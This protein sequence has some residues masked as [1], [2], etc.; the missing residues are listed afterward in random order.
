[1]HMIL[2]LRST[3]YTITK[4]MSNFTRH[5]A[6]EGMLWHEK[7]P[8]D[9]AST[10]ENTA[11]ILHG[12]L[13]QGRNWRSFGKNLAQDAR[14]ETG[15]TW[16]VLN[17][18]L[19]CHGNSSRLPGFHPPHS[20]R[21][22]ATDVMRFIQH[23]LGGVQPKLVI[24]HS[25]GGKVALEYVRLLSETSNVQ[26]CPVWV[27]DSQPGTVA[28]D[29]VPDVQRVLDAVQKVALPV[30]HRGQFTADLKA[31]GFSDALV[32]WMASNLV[33]DPGAQSA[34]STGTKGRGPL[35]WAFDVYGAAELYASYRAVNSW[36]VVA[37]P[38]PK[39]TLHVLRAARSDRWTNGMVQT[40]QDCQSA[41][42]SGHA[43]GPCGKT[44][45]HVLANAGHWVHMDQPQ[46]LQS[47]ITDE[48]AT[49]MVRN[50]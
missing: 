45:S 36:D 4:C 32:Q 1:M 14:K 8:S 25:M 17:L 42:A 34:D 7:F 47:M 5:I 12:L 24:G 49:S 50:R 37:A 18:D 39:I 11:L 15:R 44:L 20:M 30:M 38:P 28:S 9:K 27:L 13:G 40:L 26:E 22:C 31:Q 16:D 10:A 2:A 48:I 19:R 6:S 41:A 33:P 35:V 21:Q 46:V 29:Q 3:S 23:K 43:K